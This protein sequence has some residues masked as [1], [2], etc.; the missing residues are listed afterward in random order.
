MV[1]FSLNFAPTYSN[2]WIEIS[3]FLPGQHYFDNKFSTKTIYFSFPC[4][5]VFKHCILSIKRGKFSI[6]DTDCHIATLIKKQPE[7]L[8]NVVM[9]IK[10]LQILH[11]RIAN[12]QD[13]LNFAWKDHKFAMNLL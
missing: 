1:K 13:T 8:L 2:T 11:G 3:Q 9:Y 7:V 4:F 5:S 6:M 12:S 10:I